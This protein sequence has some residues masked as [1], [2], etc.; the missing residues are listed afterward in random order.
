MNTLSRLAK[1]E[2]D[3]EERILDEIVELRDYIMQTPS[4]LRWIKCRKASKMLSKLHQQMG[5]M[6]S[7]YWV[8]KEETRRLIYKNTT[9]YENINAQRY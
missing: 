7:R 5:M 3:Y 9:T 8:I 6:R 1:N 2:Q 4:W